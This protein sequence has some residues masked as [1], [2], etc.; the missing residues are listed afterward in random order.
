M[1]SLC[2]LPDVLV[3]VRSIFPY[4]QES[5]SYRQDLYMSVKTRVKL[6]SKRFIVVYYESRKREFIFIESQSRGMSR[7]LTIF[8]LLHKY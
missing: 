5:E 1:N 3:I 8:F 6:L 2:N 7:V 4:N